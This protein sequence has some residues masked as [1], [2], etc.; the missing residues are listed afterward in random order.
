[1]PDPCFADRIASSPLTM[2]DGAD[3]KVLAS[4]IGES[5]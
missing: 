3:P 5:S 4:R 2:N 1:M